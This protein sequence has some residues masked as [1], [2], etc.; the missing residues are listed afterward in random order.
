MIKKIAE[1]KRRIIELNKAQEY[2]KAFELE[3]ELKGE[4]HC[5]FCNNRIIYRKKSVIRFININQDIPI[6]YFCSKECKHQWIYK[7]QKDNSPI[8]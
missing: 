8:I 6:P 5:S 7:K 3:K 4:I 1:T 2:W